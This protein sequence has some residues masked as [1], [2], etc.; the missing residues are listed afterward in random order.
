MSEPKPLLVEISPGE[1][2]DKITILEIK[3]ARICE[4]AKLAHIRLELQVLERARQAAVALSPQ[5]DAL[6]D[7]LRIVNGKLYDVIAGIYACEAAL[8]HGARFVELARAVYRLNDRRAVLK[9]KINLL[10]GSQLMEEKGHVI[11]R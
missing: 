4:P 2:F 11:D 3:A 5:L 10:M 6:I 8:D 9:R 1:L 7:G